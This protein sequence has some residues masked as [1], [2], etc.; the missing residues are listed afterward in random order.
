MK[1]AFPG[2]PWAWAS[3]Q[4][5]SDPSPPPLKKNL[6]TGEAPRL[7]FILCPNKLKSP[8]VRIFWKS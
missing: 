5:A 7:G 6:S 2:I 4:P 8:S 1:S 3:G